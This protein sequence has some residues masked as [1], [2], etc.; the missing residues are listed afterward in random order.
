MPTNSAYLMPSPCAI[1]GDHTAADLLYPANFDAAHLNAD[2]F[3]ARRL[4]DR[5]HYQ[6]LRCKTCGL[7]RSD[8]IARHDLIE[9]L[10]NASRFTYTTEVESLKTTYGRYLKSLDDYGVAHERLLDVGCGNGFF[11]ETARELGYQDCW[12][13]EPSVDA[14][15]K[16]PDWLD[17]KIKQDIFRAGLFEENQFSVI[18]FFQVFDHFPDPAAVLDEAYRILAPNGLVLAINHDIEAL[19]A[20][21]LGSRSPIVDIEHTYLYSKTT[22]SRIFREHGFEVVSSFDVVNKYPLHYWL[23]LFPIPAGLKRFGIG[24]SKTLK[25]GN[26]PLAMRVGNQGLIARKP[27]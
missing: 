26:I 16:A 9:N 2:I 20:R 25:F 4:P 6:M 12:G 10:Y 17:G 19:Q 18:C 7:V 11:L 1:C 24:L 21:L 8:P 13:V 3:S 23:Q 22:Q 14:V 15:A 27:A 5:I